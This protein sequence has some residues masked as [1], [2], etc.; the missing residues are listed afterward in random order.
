MSIAGILFCIIAAV[1]LAYLIASAL[2]GKGDLGS[3]L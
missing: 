1:A 3:R 2:T